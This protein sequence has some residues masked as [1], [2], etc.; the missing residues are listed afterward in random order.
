[1][2]IKASRF[3][4]IG[5]TLLTVGAFAACSSDD[6][7]TG[8]NTAGTSNSHAG[9]LGVS[10]STTG[11]TPSTGGTPGTGGTSTA[12]SSAAGTS[13][14]GTSAGGTGGSGSMACAGT[15]PAS[16]LITEFAD[17]TPNATTPGQFNFTLGVPGGTFAYEKPAITVADM[18][19][20]LNAK[21]MVTTYDGFGVYLNACTDAS[22][23][24]G[25]SFSIK[26]T[27]GA[28]TMV[29][30]R[31][32]SSKNT[33]IDTVNKKGECVG[34]TYEECHDGGLDIPVTAD[35][36]VVEVKFAQLLGG[37]PVATVSGKDILGFE[38][39]F[40]YVMGDAAFAVDV[41]VDD[42]KFTG[43]APVGGSGGTGGSGGA[44]GGGAGGG[45]T[46][47]AGGTQ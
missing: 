38:W 43:G 18:G 34:T 8:G 37:V 45:G 40:P 13:S 36:K 3:Y 5:L 11:G 16:A 12:G 7:G 46:G 20:A 23:Y 27:L 24:T 30:F 41:T 15:K 35:A 6:G 21:G 42:L 31:V 28:K 1:M 39:A 17:L 9:T 32:Q 19:M 10:G 14:A 26:G 33:K 4:G 2:S 22:A 29:N 47:G 25:V 44:G